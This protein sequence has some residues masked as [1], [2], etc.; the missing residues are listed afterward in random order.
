MSSKQSF[1]E[2]HVVPK[3]DLITHEESRDCP[4][5]PINDDENIK[6]LASGDADKV[7]WVHNRILDQMN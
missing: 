1:E 7:V 2:I 4:C 6:D 5:N 3:T